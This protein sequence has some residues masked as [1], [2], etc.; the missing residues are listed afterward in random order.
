M[1]FPRFVRI[2][3]VLSGVLVAVVAVQLGNWQL[4]RADEKREI[5]ERISRFA[6]APARPVDSA[7]TE[8]PPEFSSVRLQ[9]QWLAEAVMYYDNRVH[10][11]RPGYHVLMPLRLSDGSSVL[12]NRGWVAAAADRSV[13]PSVVTPEGPV[14]VVGRVT[15]PEV[16][17]FSLGDSPRDGPRWQ[18]VDPAAYR[19]WAGIDVP[20]WVVQQTSAAPDALVRVWSPPDLGED[21]HRGYAVQWYSLAALAAALTGFHLFRSFRKHAA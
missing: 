17:P 11:R 18:F 2:V 15:V 6:D 13:L 16:D 7:A 9:G 12:V 5:G 4:R 20:G 14:E 21:T 8:S 19:E 10:E 1:R 3:P